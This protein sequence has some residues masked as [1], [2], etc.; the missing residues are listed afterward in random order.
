MVRCGFGGP[1]LA[2][3][4]A[5]AVKIQQRASGTPYCLATG[6]MRQHLLRNVQRR[7]FRRAVRRYA[8]V[9]E[10]LERRVAVQNRV[11]PRHGY[12][13]SDLP[14]NLTWC[15]SGSSVIVTQALR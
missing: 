2:L 7:E 3:L 14:V 13:E 4:D 6:R 15:G 5:F 12:M 8:A 10:G 11:A 1:G 9:V